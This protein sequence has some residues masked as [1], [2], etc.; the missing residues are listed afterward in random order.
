[1]KKVFII[2]FIFLNTFGYSQTG[3][4]WNED[5]VL[6]LSDFQSPATK[7]GN[8]NI[9]SLHS[10]ITMNFMYQMS[11]AEFMF[12][13][14]FNSAVKCVFNRNAASIIAPD[15]AIALC[16]LDFARFE[17]DLTE[18]YTRKFR[19]KM[20]EEKGA[21]SGSDFFEPIFNKIQAE[22]NVQIANAGN[23][24]DLGRNKN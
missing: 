7:I 11:N 9:Y 19:K 24:T 18:L 5:Y 20:F 15:T 22:L 12:K 13:K 4:E 1:M 3:I 14:N 21:F 17:F 10:G 23:K 8:V 16:L 2:A 6:Q